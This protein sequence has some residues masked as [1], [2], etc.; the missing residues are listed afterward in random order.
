MSAASRLTPTIRRWPP[1]LLAGLAYLI[2]T[3]IVT[4]PAVAHLTTRIAGDDSTSSD[5]LESVWG[6][7]WWKHALLDQHQ[8]PWQI[9]V[10]NHPAGQDFPLYPLMAQTFIL[11]LPLAALT[12]PV[13]AYNILF[14]A[15]FVL[16][17]LAGYALCLETS[18]NRHAA[19]VGG[20][21]WAFFPSRMAHALAGQLFL[22][23]LFTVPLAALAL[24]RV[25][26]APSLRAGLLAAVALVFAATIHPIYLPYIIAPLTIALVLETAWTEGRAFWQPPKVKALAVALGLASVAITL[27][28]LPALDAIQRGTLSRIGPL[29]DVVGFSPD[30][31]AYFVPSPNNPFIQSTPLAP[32][33]LRVQPYQYTHLIYLGW[34]PLALALIGGRARRA[35]GRVWV[36][37]ALVAGILAL[38]PLLKA[39][40]DF[41]RVTVGGESYR[42]V[43]PYVLIQNLPS[44]N[45]SR[46]PGRLTMLVMLAVSVLAAFGLERLLRT[47]ALAKR[48]AWVVVGVSLVI[49]LEYLARYPF[50]TFPAAVRGPVTALAS[51]H[52]GL[53]ALQLPING[54]Q[55]NERAL[56]WQTVHAHP[57]VGGRIYRDLPEV[58]QRYDFY[59]RLI[60]DVSRPSVVPFAE[61]ETRWAVLADSRVGWVIYDAR[62]DP[63]GLIRTQ[64]AQRLGPATSEDGGGALF[65]LPTAKLPPEST[66]WMLG[67]HWQAAKAL[68]SV[69][70]QR[71]CGNGIVYLYAAEARAARI[72]FQGTPQTEARR[73]TVRL[74]GK[75]IGQFI[76]GDTSSYLTEAADIAPG[77]NLIEFVDGG[78]L[79]TQTG[80]TPCDAGDGAPHTWGT[81]IAETRLVSATAQLPLT[82]L[83]ARF[84]A[85]LELLGFSA[86]TQ[87]A[88]GHDLPIH[89]VWRANAVVGEDLTV[90]AHLVGPDGKMVAQTDAQPLDG[91]YPTSHWAAGEVIAYTMTIALPESLPAGDYQLKLGVYSQPD[92]QRLPVSGIEAQDNAIT[93][94][95]VTI[96]P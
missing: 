78:S 89:L 95:S 48:A 60:L 25:L 45:W 88:P 42:V 39:G 6:V 63:Q 10:L 85:D 8:L 72:A 57:L 54:H 34:L 76:I 50:P 84:G 52:S 80:L 21:I 29:G 38:G 30:A 49:S 47:E 90:F 19:F 5:S 86:P 27:L 2:L 55:D 41:V 1:W 44:P 53:A 69:A 28:L 46:T 74:N 23:L 11:T 91:A 75:P 26:K 92:A 83:N 65:R 64:L 58:T 51:Y 56:Y 3:L 24:I 18:G 17:G 96:Q 9:S 87:A 62:A 14:L 16:C 36:L 71:F 43:M 15:S 35:E 77:F 13:L 68:D 70:G 33:A 20:L 4:Y 94:T 31:F 61:Y 40:G 67:P 81:A 66:L 93:L 37:I 12:T 32:F 7:W 79:D 73:V 59:R 22:I 82:T